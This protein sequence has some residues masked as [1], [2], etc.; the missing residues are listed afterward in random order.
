MRMFLVFSSAYSKVNNK[1][2][3]CIELLSL[4]EVI[5]HLNVFVRNSN[6]KL[7]LL[8]VI[9]API[10]GISESTNEHTP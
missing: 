5:K 6:I 9:I 10:S 2:A 8:M 1:E 7:M 4:L 3:S